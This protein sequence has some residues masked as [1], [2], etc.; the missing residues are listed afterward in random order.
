M[1]ALLSLFLQW[2]LPSSFSGYE[3]LYGGVVGQE[4]RDFSLEDRDVSAALQVW[5]HMLLVR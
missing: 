3:L 2:T 1:V 4:V 5:F